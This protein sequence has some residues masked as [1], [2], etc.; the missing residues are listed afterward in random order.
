MVE[1]RAAGLRCCG[2]RQRRVSELRNSVR[3][4]RYRRTAPLRHPD[5]RN[6]ELYGR[7]LTAKPGTLQPGYD[8]RRL[9]MGA[10]AEFLD[11]HRRLL[12]TILLLLHFCTIAPEELA[13]RGQQRIAEGH[14]PLVHL[15]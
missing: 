11:S 8:P 13:M 12:A 6:R 1:I 4:T 3:P 2:D 5:W 10:G 9:A 7:C 14:Q 15:G